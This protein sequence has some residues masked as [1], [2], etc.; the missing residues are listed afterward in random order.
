MFAFAMSALT[1]AQTIALFQNIHSTLLNTYCRLLGQARTWHADSR[2]SPTGNLSAP[3]HPN[4][5]G[6]VKSIEPV[7]AASTQAESDAR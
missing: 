3:S 6:I 1:L 4:H 7:Q 2:L 5:S